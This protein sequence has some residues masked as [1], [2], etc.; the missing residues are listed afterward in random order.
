MD[1]TVVLTADRRGDLLLDNSRV[2]GSQRTILML[3]NSQST[4]FNQIKAALMEHHGGIH[5]RETPK[6]TIGHAGGTFRRSS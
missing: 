1:P 2:N 4:D 5:K 6:S 3:I